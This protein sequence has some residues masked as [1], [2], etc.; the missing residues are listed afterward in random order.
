[1]R[2]NNQTI[3]RRLSKQSFLANKS[4]N[5]FALIAIVLTTILITAVFT[6]GISLSDGMQ[7][8]LIHSYRAQYGGGFSY[9]IE[10]EAQRV[11]DI[12]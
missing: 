5:I 11:A 10:D 6:I 4:R 9:L 8:M 7:Q 2:N 3:V 12:R 1:M